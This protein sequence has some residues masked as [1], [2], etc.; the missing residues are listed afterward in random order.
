MSLIAAYEAGIRSRAPVKNAIKLREM[1]T[2]APGKLAIRGPKKTRRLERM[3]FDYRR[4]MPP[5][6][7]SALAG[8]NGSGNLFHAATI[9]AWVKSHPVVAGVLEGRTSTPWLPPGVKYSEEASAWLLGTETEPGWREQIT[10]PSELESISLDDYNAGYGV[11]CFVWNNKRGRPELT[12]LD[13][14]GLRYIAGEDRYQYHGF[15]NVFDVEPGNSIWV[16]KARVKTDPWREGAWHKIAYKICN[17]ELAEMQRSVWMQIFGMPTVLATSPQGA[18]DDQKISFTQKVIGAALRVIGVTPGYSLKFEQATAEG[19]DTFAQALAELERSIS[20]L[21]WGT[22]GLIS[23]G[24]G[25]SNSDLFERMKAAILEKEARKQA[26]FEN[27]QIWPVALDWACR[28]GKIS[29][30][31]K[32]ACIVY[33]AESAAVIAQKAAAAKALIECGYSQEEA[34]QRVGLEKHSM[35]ERAPES[36]VR[37]LPEARDEEPIEPSYSEKLA[38]DMNARNRVA[39]PH[40]TVDACRKC[41]VVLRYEAT[42]DGYKPVWHSYAKRAA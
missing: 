30:A 23:G 4:W 1:P 14:A 6:I 26:R 33:N 2:R 28:A 20:I 17:S 19:S 16:L 8:A 18:S 34:Q 11:G 31:A 15:G 5:D 36:G 41:R 25:F 39:C 22:M 27:E 10:D 42:D 3:A 38:L 37:M 35:P 12:A 40:G 7:E 9:A 24:S 32:N 29:K 13:N 21:A